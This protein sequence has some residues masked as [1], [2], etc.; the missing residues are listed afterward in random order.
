[1]LRRGGR[2][3]GMRALN[4]LILVALVGAVLCLVAA[5]L[6]VAQVVPVAPVTVL[7]AF[8]LCFG[9]G[10]GAMALRALG[11]TPAGDEPAHASRTVRG[12]WVGYKL[13]AA[14]VALAGAVYLWQRG[15]TALDGALGARAAEHTKP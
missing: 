7:A 2:I 12:L 6:A 10:K 15:P 5:I 8:L 4:H 14:A 13:L 3:S 9:V 1:M 11:P